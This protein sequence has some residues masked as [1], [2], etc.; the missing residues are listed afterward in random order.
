MTK[1]LDQMGKLVFIPFQTCKGSTID[2]P[3]C[4]TASDKVC[5][6]VSLCGETVFTQVNYHSFHD[7]FFYD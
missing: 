7:D 2:G 3:A 6:F 5:S 4:G 1:I